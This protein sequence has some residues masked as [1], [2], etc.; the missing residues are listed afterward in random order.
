MSVVKLRRAG[1]TLIELLVV[2]AIIGILA[3]ILLPVLSRAKM[4]AVAAS[5]MS[6][7]KQLCLAWLMYAGD[8]SDNLAINSDPHISNFY[9]GTPT[10]VTGTIDWTTGQ[11]NTNTSYLT[12]ST[13]SLL[14]TYLGG[15]V[16]VFACPAANYLTPAQKALGWSQRIRSVAMNGAV[17]DGHKYLE[18]AKPFSWTSW[19]YARKMSDF[20]TPGPSAVWVFSDEHP[21]SI[22]D[23][24]MYTASYPVTSFTE[25]PGSQHG[26]ACGMAFADGH[27]LIHRWQGSVATVPVNYW[28]GASRCPTGPLPAGRQQVDCSISDPDMLF[29][30][31]HT[32]LN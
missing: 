24:L 4:R 9:L 20:H 30:A 5:C 14:G 23:A 26:G 11:E 17:G 25:L 7:N 2:I 6:N 3:S 1:F 16:Q 8:N 13:H 19:Y 21:D 27:A 10:W 15:S 32:P 29:L 22:D 31:A 18:P 28:N 12:D